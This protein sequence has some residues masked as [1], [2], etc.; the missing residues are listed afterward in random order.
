MIIAWYFTEKNFM[1]CL[2]IK[3]RGVGVQFIN[4]AAVKIQP[5]KNLVGK[6]D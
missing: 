1:R 3:T 6:P 2:I 4:Y 5:L